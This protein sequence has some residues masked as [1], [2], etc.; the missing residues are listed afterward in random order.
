MNFR[1]LVFAASACTAAIASA[2][3]AAQ[4]QPPAAAP[5]D[6]ASELFKKGNEAYKQK[7]WA[8][9][10]KAFEEAF[11]LKQAYDIA[12]N[13]G[14]VELLQGKHQEAAEHLEYSLRNWPAGQ[15]ANR[16]RTAERYAEAKQKIGS[17]TLKVS[18]GAEITVNGKS[19]GKSPLPGPVFVSPGAATVIA[20]IGDKTM[21][22]TVALDVGESREVEIVIEGEAAAVGPV[23]PPSENGS[24]GAS[25]SGSATGDVKPPTGSSF[26]TIGMIASGAVAVIGL[27]VGV[28]FYMKKQSAKDE[29]EGFK[30]DSIKQVGAGGCPESGATGACADL[31]D[32]NDRAKSARTIST[33]GFIGAGVG[34]AAFVAFVLMPSKKHSAVVHPVLDRHTAG[35]AAYGSF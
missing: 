29:A 15:E 20:T 24:A 30:D 32:A 11:A 12:G 28:G 14:D 5:S 26:K 33:V 25:A 6:E 7:K 10:E 23:A 35:L 27:G 22:K 18:E 8:E 19:V 3:T 34:A 31:A 13:L 9:A 2:P 4:A 17:L 1:A 21:K 16:K